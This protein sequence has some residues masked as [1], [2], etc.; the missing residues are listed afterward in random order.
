MSNSIKTPIQ[1]NPACAN[2]SSATSIADRMKALYRQL[3]EELRLKQLEIDRLQRE[4]DAREAEDDPDE[5]S[6]PPAKPNTN[7]RAPTLRRRS[8]LQAQK[9][10]VRQRTRQTNRRAK[11]G[12]AQP[13]TTHAGDGKE[14]GQHNT[15]ERG[16][17]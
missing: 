13:G 6:L 3:Q 4:L 15:Q 7:P 11:I 10:P 9:A 1:T 14:P 17:P 2:T 16:P 8:R 5:E 12:S